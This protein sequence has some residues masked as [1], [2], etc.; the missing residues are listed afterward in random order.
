MVGMTVTV[1]ID[2]AG[3][4]VLPKRLRQRFRLQGGDH[5]ALEV[6]GDAIQLRPV[7]PTVRL[8][9]INGVLVLVSDMALPEGRDLVFESRDERLDEIAQGASELE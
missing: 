8:E 5:L 9:R 4:V 1:K 3:R 7:K 6:K 2:Q